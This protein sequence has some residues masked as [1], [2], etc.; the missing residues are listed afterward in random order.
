LGIIILLTFF[1]NQVKL[2]FRDSFILKISRLMRKI[3]SLLAVL[4]L[5]SVSAFAQQTRLISGQVKDEQGEPIPFATVTIK[6]TKKGVTTDVNG[7]FR[8]T[9][10][11]G[12][13]LVFTAVGAQSA[14]ATVTDADILSATLLKTG[15]LQEVVVTALGVQRQAKELGYSMSRIRNS[16]I[17]QAKTVNL[18][19]GLT[20]K[21]SGLNITTVNSGV[22]EETKINLRG[23]RSLTGNNQPLLTID[24]IPTPL[25][26]IYTLNPNDVQDVNI[27]K[28][29]SAAAI[30]GS[31]GVNGVILGMAN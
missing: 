8:I 15:A 22:F 30:Y 4:V 2:V 10:S 31:D 13:V 12:D 11:T 21:V 16:E 9:A 1:A 27:L 19:N 6:G 23:I 17:N 28:G 20:G 14:E 25:S 24:N 26:Y 18:Q 3:L 29:A 5:L 7:N